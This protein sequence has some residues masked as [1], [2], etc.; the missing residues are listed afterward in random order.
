MTTAAAPNNNPIDRVTHLIAD[1]MHPHEY[2]LNRDIAIEHG[3]DV[4]ASTLGGV[5]DGLYA[6]KKFKKGDPIGSYAGHVVS[7]ERAKRL[8]A[9][10]RQYVLD[11]FVNN[12]SVD[13]HRDANML[14]RYIREHPNESM[15]NCEFV[16]RP[17]EYIAIAYA[18]RDIEVGEEIYAVHHA[19]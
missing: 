15:L 11:G 16:R 18:T 13:A 9:E 10:Q 1:A 7:E 8:S 12:M 5:G 4:R 3:L 17:H 19:V 14:T 2:P 6:A